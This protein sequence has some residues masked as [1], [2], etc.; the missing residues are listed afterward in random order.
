[1]DKLSKIDVFSQPFQLYFHKK[2]NYKTPLGGFMTLFTLLFMISLFFTQGFELIYKDQP[3]TS[4]TT[5]YNPY[6]SSLL[7]G[8][9][10]L[11]KNNKPFFDTSVFTLNSYQYMNN[12]TQDVNSQSRI[13]LKVNN[14]SELLSSNG[15]FSDIKSEMGTSMLCIGDEEDNERTQNSQYQEY[16]QNKN[17]IIG[18]DVNSIYTAG[19]YNKKLNY[20]S[21]LHINL[22]PCQNTSQSQ[23]C[24][25][26]YIINSI[27]RESSFNIY[28]VD[29]E[30]NPNSF[31]PS[32]KPIIKT[33]V[34]KIDPLLHK[35]KELYFQSKKV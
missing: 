28:Y 22:S 27:L 34:V 33:Y 13:K 18:G 11:D 8:I 9:Q 10:I 6:T 7:L 25:P 16:M 29:S 26:I 1:M 4:I 31:Y 17:K 12:N 5:K 24:K 15:L 23:L 30:Y 14:C 32:I 19:E 20:S 35:T 2:N 3:I 21:N